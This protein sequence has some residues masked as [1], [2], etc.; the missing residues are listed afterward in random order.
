MRR[1]YSEYGKHWMYFRF[2]WHF[3]VSYATCG[4]FDAR[5]RINISLIFFSWTIILPLWSK[6]TDEC[7]PPEWGIAIHNN[8]FWLYKG[9][10]GNMNGGTKWWT[11]TMPWA[12]DWVRTSNLRK[13]GTWEHE[14]KGDRKNFYE[15]EWKEVIWNETYPYVYVLKN[16]TVQKRETTIKVVEREWRPLWFKWTSLFKKIHRDI[17]VTFNDEVGERTGS[18]KGG[19]IGCSYKMIDPE[20]PHQTLKRMERERKFK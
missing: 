6:H 7:V 19:T 15:D 20:L 13:D 9:G 1:S 10:K 5:H 17:D 11:F 16:G 3:R 4:Y 8:I 14:R 2:G 12:Y 18:W